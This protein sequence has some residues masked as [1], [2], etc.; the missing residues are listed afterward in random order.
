MKY[1]PYCGS[2]LANGDALFCSECGESLA[3]AVPEPDVPKSND[4]DGKRKPA[5]RRRKQKKPKQNRQA[6]RDIPSFQP[7]GME[8]QEQDDGYDGYYDDI[9]PVDEGSHGEGLDKELVKKIAALTA[10]ALLI[11]AACV[12]LMYLL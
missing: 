6:A 3:G 9:L 4:K 7:D 5:K 2:V 10:G 12:A 11:V 1:C 8:V